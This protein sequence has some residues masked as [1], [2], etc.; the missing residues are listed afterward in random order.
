[1][2][3]DGIEPS[4]TWAADQLP[5]VGRSPCTTGTSSWSVGSSP[6]P[7]VGDGTQQLLQ[8]LGA[9]PDAPRSHPE[10][11]QSAVCNA[12]ADGPGRQRRVCRRLLDREQPTGRP[13]LL[14]NRHGTAFPVLG[15]PSLRRLP[16]RHAPRLPHTAKAISRNPP[17]AMDV[18]LE[19]QERGPGD[20][21][22]HRWRDLVDRRSGQVRP[23]LH[24]GSEREGGPRLDGRAA[25]LGDQGAERIER[26]AL[27]S[28]VDYVA[29]GAFTD[30]VALR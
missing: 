11:R 26:A 2:R 4:T 21:P 12:A 8:M 25:L 1:M 19:C 22:E 14:L 27:A 5:S 30:P 6:R 15:L 7:S 20:L 16:H 3:D 13:G 9:D 28:Q 24:Q 29:R 10:R 23:R 18:R 17:P